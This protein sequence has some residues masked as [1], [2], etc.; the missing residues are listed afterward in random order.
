G[1]VPRLR[2]HRGRTGALPRHTRPVAVGVARALSGGAGCR[3]SLAT[4][5]GGVRAPLCEEGADAAVPRD[6]SSRAPLDRAHARDLAD[7]AAAR[8]A[9]ERS[10]A[11]AARWR[12]A[13]SRPLAPASRRLRVPRRLPRVRR[14]RRAR[15]DQTPIPARRSPT[16]GV[17]VAALPAT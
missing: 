15:A 4:L 5:Q 1:L 16:F 14:A 12:D 9:R 2:E 11:E 3:L 17:P 10:S 6:E 7:A 13:P 8:P